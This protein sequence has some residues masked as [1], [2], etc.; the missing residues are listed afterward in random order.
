MNPH[1]IVPVGTQ[2]VSRIEVKNKQDRVLCLQGGLGVIIQSPTDNSHS[3]RIRLPNDVEITL[4]R[5]EFSIR[6]HYQ[7][8]G[9]EY[10]DDRLAEL[11]LYLNFLLRKITK[12]FIKG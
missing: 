11:N 4:R 8:Q 2:V 12:A 6:K 7:K 10:Q 3:Y 9:L 5:H 1:L